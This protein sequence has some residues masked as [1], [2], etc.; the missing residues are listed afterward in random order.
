MLLKEQGGY[1]GASFKGRKCHLCQTVK[2][3]SDGAPQ[4]A[5]RVGWASFAATREQ[6][7]PGAGRSALPAVLVGGLS[8][9]LCGLVGACVA[10]R[11]SGA[12]GTPAGV[13]PL[14]AAAGLKDG[15]EEV[16]V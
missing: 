14:R 9:L 6:P 3:D 10:R 4:L 8:V 12:E 1:E 16:D 11:R 7:A 15:E 13:T 5:S 2:R